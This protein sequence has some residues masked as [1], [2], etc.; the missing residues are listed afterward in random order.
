MALLFF[1]NVDAE[2]VG[3][4]GQYLLTLSWPYDLAVLTALVSPLL[5]P[6]LGKVIVVVNGKKKSFIQRE[7]ATGRSRCLLC[8]MD[9][10]LM[11]H[12]AGSPPTF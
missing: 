2:H 6:F 8:D 9:D 4:V 7:E 12:M 1:H 11:S 3:Q 10:A 5:W